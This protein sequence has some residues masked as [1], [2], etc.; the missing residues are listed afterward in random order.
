MARRDARARL[1]RRAPTD[2]RIV[3]LDR[4]L[5]ARVDRDLHPVPFIEID[6]VDY[7]RY[8]RHGFGFCL[9]VGRAIASAVY[10]IAVSATHA[11][12]NVFT[13]A[14]FRRRGF[15]TRVS[16][17][18]IAHCLENGHLP[19]WDCD[20]VNVASAATAARLGFVEARP[21]VELGMPERSGLQMSRGR[22]GAGR[23][24]PG[25]RRRVAS[26]QVLAG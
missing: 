3:P 2:A 25:G 13:A 4:A 19:V 21:F 26:R 16:A 15:A 6:W 9:L 12:V 22:V 10:A 23:A 8:A 14:R 1:A 17:R 5:A 18:F 7:D 24:V 20:R 11:M